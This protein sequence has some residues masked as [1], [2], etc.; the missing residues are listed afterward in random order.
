VKST[1]PGALRKLLP[2]ISIGR[3]TGLEGLLELLIFKIEGTDG[4][5]APPPLP[6]QPTKNAAAVT[7]MTAPTAIAHFIGFVSIFRVSKL[8]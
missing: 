3:P 5:V 1:L 2:L 6:E 7:I 4:L 8:F